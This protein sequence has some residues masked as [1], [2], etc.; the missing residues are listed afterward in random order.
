MSNQIIVL[1]HQ[2]WSYIKRGHAMH[3][4]LTAENLIVNGQAGAAKVCPGDNNWWMLKGDIEALAMPQPPILKLI[5]YRLKDEYR[6]TTTFPRSLEDGA[7]AYSDDSDE[8]VPTD[9]KAV[10]KHEFYDAVHERIE[11]QPLA[12]E[13]LSVDK[14]TAP[15]AKPADVVVDF[16][17]LLREHPE[18]WYK[19]PVSISGDA[20]FH[21]AVALLRAEVNARPNDFQMKDY[22]NIGT[23]TLYRVM[24][25]KPTEYT[26]HVGKKTKRGSKTQSQVEILMIS[27]PKSSYRDGAVVPGNIAAGNWAELEPKIDL[28]LETIRAYIAPGHVRLC[29]HC[30]GEGFLIGDS[31]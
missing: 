3:Y 13:F 22:T 6:D 31:Q 5:G 21:R 2:G 23:F 25:H 28:F 12:L 10:Y 7:F 19:H 15:K 16:P 14:D 27:S 24:H 18:T 9:S 20:L 8:W 11:R 4:G 29:P 30:D 17:A 26:Y 1:Q